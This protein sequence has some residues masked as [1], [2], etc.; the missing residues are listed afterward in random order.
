MFFDERRAHFLQDRVR[1]RIRENAMESFYHYYKLL[2]G[3]K[4]RAEIAALVDHLT[5]NETSFFRNK[6]QLELFHKMTLDEILHRK[7]Q[8]RDWSL[9][10]WSAGCSTGQEPYTMAM[11]ICD[12]LRFITYATLTD[13]VALA[14]TVV[15]PPWK[16]ELFASDISYRVFAPRRREVTPKP[17][18]NRSTIPTVCAIRQDQ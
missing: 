2:T 16:V 11:L 15:P 8:R 10:I 3:P 17:R 7:H 4:G 18:W 1:R 9:K 12:A 13:R 14:E 5:I 6:P